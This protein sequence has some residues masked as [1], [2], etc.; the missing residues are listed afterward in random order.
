[1]RQ[2]LSGVSPEDYLANKAAVDLTLQNAIAATMT[3]VQPEDITDIGIDESESGGRRLAGGEVH[4]RYMVITHVDGATYDSLIAQLTAASET[5]AL[6]DLIQEF[7][8]EFGVPVLADATVS[9]PETTNLLADRGTSEL[10]TGTQIAG[11]IIG[12]FLCLG[13][14]ATV[15]FFILNVRN[16]LAAAAGSPNAGPSPAAPVTSST[17]LELTNQV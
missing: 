16:D 4:L 13:L 6:N 17:T 8:D 10:L 5:S 15:V 12:I 2:T 1:M 9:E 3:G 14:I 7:A 11:L